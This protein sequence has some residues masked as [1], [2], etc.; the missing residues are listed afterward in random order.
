MGIAKV[1]VDD[2]ILMMGNVS[3]AGSRILYNFVPP[4]NAAVIDKLTEAG[5]K[6][7]VQTKPNEFGASLT[8]PFGCVGAVARGEAD[9]GIGCDVNGTIRGDAAKNGVFFIKPTYGTV[10]RFGLVSTAPSMEQIGV[11]CSDAAGCFETL[12]MIT[13]RDERDGT[14]AG[15]EKTVFSPPENDL[16]GVKLGVPATLADKTAKSAGI[17]KALGAEVEAFEFPLLNHVSGV[18]YVIAAAETCNSI[19]RFDGIKFGYRP[20]GYANLEDIYAKSRTECFSFETKLLAL[21]GCL[22]LTKEKYDAYYSRSLKIRRLIKEATD[23]ALSKYD[24]VMMPTECASDYKSNEYAA[25]AHAS[26]DIHFC[27][28]YENLKCLALPNLTGS[29]AL[30]M[31]GGVQFMA[32]PFGENTLYRLGK[33]FQNYLKLETNDEL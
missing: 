22:V 5:V 24:A 27:R 13:G 3:T 28:S 8:V 21:M 31:P 6:D 18:S 26:A 29:P 14:L 2:N 4:Y 10:S 19:S 32:K 33:N 20:E 15:M 17:L 16:S 30:S 12:S 11:A 23:S 7:I 9:A 1:A 25:T